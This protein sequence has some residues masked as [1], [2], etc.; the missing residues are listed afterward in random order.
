MKTMKRW[1]S[2]LLAAAMIFTALPVYAADPATNNPLEFLYDRW[3]EQ[4]FV[5]RV[6]GKDRYET[7]TQVSNFWLSSKDVVLA[8]GENF[9]D[10]LF[11]GPL[12]SALKAPMLLT[13]KDKLPDN[14]ISSI[15]GL[16][17]KVVYLLGGE[18]S[19]SKTVEDELKKADLAV[20]RLAGKDRFETAAS[21]AKTTAL[22]YGTQIL[23]DEYLVVNGYQFADALTAAPYAYYAVGTT[24]WGSLL[25]FRQAQSPGKVIGGLNSV[26][27][28][29]YEQNRIAGRDR[30]E[31]ATKIAQAIKDDLKKEIKS[32]FVV[33]GADYPDALAAG[34]A[35]TGYPQEGVILLTEPNK[36][37]AF[38]KAFLKEN[39]IQ[40]VYIIG[41]ENSVSEAVEA[42]LNEVVGDGQTLTP[43]NYQVVGDHAKFESVPANQ[44]AVR[45]TRA[46]SDRA[47]VMFG[48][49]V[50]NLTPNKKDFAKNVKI[51]A[52]QGTKPLVL[53]NE[54]DVPI[55]DSL[56][57]N[58]EFVP[59]GS[60]YLFAYAKVDTQK[61]IEL[62]FQFEDQT[63]K[64]QFRLEPDPDKKEF[65]LKR[66][67]NVDQTVLSL[68]A[69][70]FLVDTG[71]VKDNQPVMV[72]DVLNQSDKKST[73]QDAFDISVRQDGKESPVKA[74][75]PSGVAD[76]KSWETWFVGHKVPIGANDVADKFRFVSD[77]Q[78]KDGA[79]FT[80]VLRLKSDP[81][82]I[83]E[84]PYTVEKMPFEGVGP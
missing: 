70:K 59:Y 48:I 18:N 20:V 58:Q 57:K 11:G 13:K 34:P 77:M 25:P 74:I 44:Y 10:A 19:I 41:G 42:E 76:R 33:S 1:I 84:I 82:K 79:L 81:K 61:P 6:Q 71:Y 30:Y 68:G 16:D 8:S 52:S 37:N 29:E 65:S 47:E 9:A 55:Y 60:L 31:T 28:L 4:K 80:L 2:T 12:A 21:I 72:V 63:E 54:H 40:R 22:T 15:K 5:I 45:I 36:L 51:E 32:V 69:F 39:K 66:D 75:L 14:L 17:A 27:K 67:L 7:A 83:L 3:E 38:T 46:T 49:E 53:T 35:V 23:P 43:L 24:A 50:K 73:L 56:W 64:I 26:P 62:T 78:P